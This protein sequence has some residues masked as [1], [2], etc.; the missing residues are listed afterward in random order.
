MYA[1]IIRKIITY[2]MNYVGSRVLISEKCK[3]AC[4]S[5]WKMHS[6]FDRWKLQ[7][8]AFKIWSGHIEQWCDV[9]SLD[10][11]DMPLPLYMHQTYVL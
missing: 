8:R 10:A 9:G 1:L 4:M 3:W 5:I 7:V 2:M 6:S 11:S